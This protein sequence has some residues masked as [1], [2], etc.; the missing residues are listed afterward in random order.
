METIKR[1]IDPKLF[2]DIPPYP[3][4]SVIKLDWLK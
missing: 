3:N 4:A 1:G 2:Y